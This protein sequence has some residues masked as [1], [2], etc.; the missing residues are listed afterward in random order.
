DDECVSR[1]GICGNGTCTNVIGSFRCSCNAGFEQGIDNTCQDINECNGP[2][3]NCAFRCVNI[4]GSFAC[5]CPMGYSLASDGI[6]CQDVDECQTQA[7]TCRYACKNLVGSF[8][9]ICP[10]GY[11]EIG[12]NQCV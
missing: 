1:P 9:C 10:E 5:I 8:M 12:P 11:R 6:H 7:N 2:L 3:N 4:P